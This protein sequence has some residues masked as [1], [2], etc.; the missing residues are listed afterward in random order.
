[1]SQKARGQITIT[2]LNDA[3]TVN[4]FLSSNKALTQVFTDP[5]YEPDFSGSSPLVIT[6]E[7]Y[8]SGDNS[9][10]L[11]SQCAA[12][13][14][15]TINGKTP[16]EFGATVGGT[17][18]WALTI[19]KNMAD[20]QQW[21]IVCEAEWTDTDTGL[22]T[23]VKADLTL[24]KVVNGGTL[25]FAQIVGPTVLKNDTQSVTLEAQLVRGGQSEPDTTDVEYQWQLLGTGGWKDVAG[26]TA[27]TLKVSASDVTNIAS[28][29][30]AITDKDS[31]SGTYNQT[32]TSAQAD[33]V[34]MSDP[35]SVRMDTTNGT[36]LV[37]GQ[38][39]TVIT[40]VILRGGYEVTLASNQASYA[41]SAVDKDGSA[42]TLTSTQQSGK[43]L[44]VTKELVSV[45]S[46]F[47]C[48]VTI[49]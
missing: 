11:I 41:W 25:C 21:H 44:E 18:P 16:S 7:I 31:M 1:M 49:G 33:V 42:I 37:N 32:F 28:Y 8:A 15:W 3:K 40:P 22:T 13:P 14:S 27:R 38:G 20:A 30:V 12:A 47:I 19:N 29:R 34:D 2:D 9:G 24:A 46:T 5:S 4:M 6:P 45:K 26:A 36:V 17:S 23:K 35:Y 43:T 10:N 39:S 48:D